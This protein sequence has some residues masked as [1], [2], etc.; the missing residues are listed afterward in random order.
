MIAS[1]KQKYRLVD[2]LE[3]KKAEN[4]ASSEDLLKA[5]QGNERKK[6]SVTEN[7]VPRSREGNVVSIES[8]RSPCIF[9]FLTVNTPI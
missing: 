7:S 2:T 3:I 5:V 1:K 4:L 9:Y 6:N 8:L